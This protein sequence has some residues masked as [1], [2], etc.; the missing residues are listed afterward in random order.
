MTLL[1]RYAEWVAIALAL[2]VFWW[3]GH[4]DWGIETGITF[5]VVILVATI[6]MQPW[7]N[8]HRAQR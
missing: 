2:A 4:A 6:L 3:A 7:L 1:I 8:Q 5:F